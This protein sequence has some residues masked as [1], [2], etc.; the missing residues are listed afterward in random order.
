MR[1]YHTSRTEILAAVLAFAWPYL[2]AKLDP[3]KLYP[4]A[5]LNNPSRSLA[6]ELYSTER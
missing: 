2:A 4:A 6:A 5:R 1:L 3:A